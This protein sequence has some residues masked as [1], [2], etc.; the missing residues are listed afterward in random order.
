MARYEHLPLYKTAMELT[1]YIETVVRT[2][3]RYHKY[4]LGTDLRQQSRALVTVIIR[5]NSRR[6]KVPV[7]VDLRER[8]EA[9][10]V[11]LRIC[12]E[13]K[14]FAKFEAYAQAAQ[15]AVALGRQNEGWIKGQAIRRGR[16]TRR[17]EF[18]A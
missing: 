6:E 7:L 4:T 12:K 9:F 14:A 1:V 3:S 16:E 5:A 18:P 17:P 13:V 15:L 10:Q 8:V 11:L 2:F